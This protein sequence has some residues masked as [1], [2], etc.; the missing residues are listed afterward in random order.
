MIASVDLDDDV[1]VHHSHKVI[2]KVANGHVF[3]I[4]FSIHKWLG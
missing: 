2:S 3:E 4:A 1:V